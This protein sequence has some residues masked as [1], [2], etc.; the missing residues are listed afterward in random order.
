MIYRGFKIGPVLDWF[1]IKQAHGFMMISSAATLEQARQW[2]DQCRERQEAKA[3]T[4]REPGI[5]KRKQE[6]SDGTS[7]I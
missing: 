6:N 1:A 2:V 3:R 4:R 7:A 5:S